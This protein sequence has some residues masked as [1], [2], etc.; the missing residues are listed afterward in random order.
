[1]RSSSEQNGRHNQ[2]GA[3]GWPSADGLQGLF[4]N[5]MMMLHGRETFCVVNDH[6]K[7]KQRFP[8]VIDAELKNLNQ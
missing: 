8:Q 7:R 1:M 5:H 2:W 3:K 6:E 4:A